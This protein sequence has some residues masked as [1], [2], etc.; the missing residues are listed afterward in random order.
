[1]D[2]VAG[3]AVDAAV[4]VAVTQTDPPAL[5]REL[6][7]DRLPLVIGYLHWLAGT[8]VE[9]G[10]IGP[11]EADRLWERHILNCAAIAPLIQPAST[12][13]DIG[14]G[15]GLPG[16][17]LA[18]ARPDLD[19]VLIESMSRRTAFL[20]DVI[21]DLGLNRVT[22]RRA[23]A[24]EIRRGELRADVVTARALAP[25]DRLARWAAPLL[26]PGG[27]V[28]AIKGDTAAAE[29]T[30]AWAAVA[31]AGFSNGVLVSMRHDQTAAGTTNGASLTIVEE[32]WWGGDETP[33]SPRPVGSAG[34]T[35]PGAEFHLARVVVLQ[36]ERNQLLKRPPSRPI[37][38]LG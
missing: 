28:L 11:R 7:G 6:F 18:M 14:S 5:A 25:I 10:L 23:R 4:S 8:G 19:L 33:A 20:E 35:Q 29:V 26:A 32:A 37:R 3:S 9:R 1:M 36:R 21:T 31:R 12:V 27:A 24:E 38:G 17:V 34:A 2:S 13:V 15:A 22:V 30:T 16:L